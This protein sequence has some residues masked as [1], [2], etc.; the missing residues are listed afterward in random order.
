MFQA[1]PKTIAFEEFL[2]WKPDGG[3]YEL[4]DGVIVE[5]QPVGDRNKISYDRN[6]DTP[7]GPRVT[8]N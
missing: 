8:P 3:R 4:H 6:A 7:K 2:N 1:S 5:M